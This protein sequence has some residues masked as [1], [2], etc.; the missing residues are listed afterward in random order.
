MCCLLFGGHLLAKKYCPGIADSTRAGGSTTMR[1]RSAD[2]RG[3]LVSPSWV[4]SRSQQCCNLAH[5]VMTSSGPVLQ[6]ALT[7]QKA[8]SRDRLLQVRREDGRGACL[9]KPKAA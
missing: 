1:G 2:G 4:S 8:V 6:L 7:L 3:L 9:L 5:K